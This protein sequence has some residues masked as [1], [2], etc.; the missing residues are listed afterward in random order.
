MNLRTSVQIPKP[1][2]FGSFQ[3]K[4][5]VLFEHV[6]NDPNVKEYGTTG[7]AQDGIDLLGVRRSEAP[8]HWVGVQC[9]L[10]IKAERLK[11]G[12]VSKEATKAL[13][14]KPAL[15]EFI[16]VTTAE[17]DVAMDKEAAEFTDEQAKLGQRRR[18]R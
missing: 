1:G 14:I 13:E 6:L 8:D 17:D 16:V 18:W 2:D 3:R 10:T 12:T 15:K 11:K 4:S 9:K 5:K 7:Q